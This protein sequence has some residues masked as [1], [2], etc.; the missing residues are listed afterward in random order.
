MSAPT[1][2]RS[3]G[4]DA[5]RRLRRDRA[6]MVGLVLVLVLLLACLA[7]PWIAPHDPNLQNLE[8]QLSPPSWEHIFGTDDKGRDLF[9]RVL[10]G[11]R[12]SWTVG[13]L[14][15][16]V[17]IVIGVTWGSVA[18]YFGGIVDNVMMRIVDVLYTIPFLFLAILFMVVARTMR[19]AAGWE[20]NELYLVFVAIGAVSWLTVSR[21][22]RGEVLSIRERDYIQAAHAL[23]FGHVRI[24]FRHIVPNLIGVVVVYS[25]LTVPRV[26]LEE[27]FLSFLGLGVQP[28][29][30]SWGSLAAI[31][32]EV[33]NPVHSYW[34][35][36]VFPGAV[37]ALTL[38]GLNF[39][40]DGLRDALDPR[41]RR[42]PGAG[43]AE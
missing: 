36:I 31:G 11:G 27:S 35:L 29:D 24:L 10:H 15:T 33:I 22:V 12:V 18:A 32:A 13:L 38:F 3:P 39:L 1:L 28:P 40:G 26:M 8:A 42:G 23:G 2:I 5:W 34:W 7:A 21:I 9:S 30:A 43:Y 17:S 19:E 16:T 6:A 20:I 14:A 41:S 4:R 37:L 25:S